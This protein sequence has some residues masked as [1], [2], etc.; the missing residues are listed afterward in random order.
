VNGM[1]YIKLLAA[2][3]L[4]ASIVWVIKDPGFESG[5]SVLGSLSALVSAFVFEKRRARL[6][7]PQSVSKSSVGIQAGG[8]VT[9]GS[10]G[11][12]KRAK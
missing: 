6:S 2:T 1:I 9:V 12:D 5:L 7:Q 4:I 8:D 10:N 3:A 11:G